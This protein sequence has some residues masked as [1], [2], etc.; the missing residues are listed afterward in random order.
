MPELNIKNEEVN[1]KPKVDLS[2]I[3]EVRLDNKH[4]YIKYFDL[5]KNK[6]VMLRIDIGN[7]STKE[8]IEGIQRGSISFNSSD[9]LN[10][11]MGILEMEAKRT[12]VNLT[13]IPIIE[14]ETLP[15]ESL[16]K[17]QL[18]FIKIIVKNK[19]S[20][21]PKLKF[22]N[23][24]EL[25]VIDENNL[26][27]QCVRDVITNALTFKSADVVK[28]EKNQKIETNMVTGSLDDIDFEAEV[29][30]IVESYEPVLIKGYQFD[31]ETMELYTEKPNLIEE[32][33]MEEKQKSIWR[34]LVEYYKKRKANPPKVRKLTLDPHKKAGFATERLTFSLSICGILLI[35]IGVLILML[36]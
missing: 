22:I 18:D 23:L 17:D 2:S 36:K 12:R 1:D 25:L 21:I 24:E 7:N 4:R 9:A 8:I 30:S 5:N 19:D 29:S 28:Y 16:N 35:L 15:L 13:I 11:T 33:K 3:E 26:V 6:P 32:S 14:M 20:Y 34:K 10:N 27:K 31:K